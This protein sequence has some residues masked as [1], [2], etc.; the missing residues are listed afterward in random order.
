MYGKLNQKDDRGKQV[1]QIW[2][3]IDESQDQLH[4]TLRELILHLRIL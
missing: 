4:S 1:N 3:L 2:D